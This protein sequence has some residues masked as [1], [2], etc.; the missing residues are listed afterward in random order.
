[1]RCFSPSVVLALSF[2]GAVT[3]VSCSDPGTPDPT[4]NTGALS[5]ATATA[6]PSMPA[7]SLASAT[8]TPS[9]PTTSGAPSQVPTP[10]ATAAASMSATMVPT[11]MSATAMPS[12]LP[13]MSAVASAMPSLTA[14]P[15]ASM[16]PAEPWTIEDVIHLFFNQYTTDD[17]VVGQCNGCHIGGDSPDP[18]IPVTAPEFREFLLG[19]TATKCGGRKLLVP[20]EP[21]ESAIFLLFE[22]TCDNGAGGMLKMPDNGLEPYPHNVAGIRSWI[23]AGAAL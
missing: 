23:E 20:G 13:S 12:V 7:P 16:E 9:A 14:A 15:S 21:E 8:T 17:P 10:S 11:M 3:A 19:Y 1:M 5:G 22:G 18:H 6:A 2:A 4:D